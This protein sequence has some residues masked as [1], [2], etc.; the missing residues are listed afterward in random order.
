[1]SLSRRFI[2]V[3][4]AVTVVA[5]VV[6]SAVPAQAEVRVSRPGSTASINAAG[7]A[8]DPA[9]HV[10]DGQVALAHGAAAADVREF[11]AGYAASGGQIV[12][13]TPDAALSSMMNDIPMPRAC[14]GKNRQ[15]TTGLQSNVYI[16]SCVTQRVISL[17]GSGAGLAGI[18]AAV[19]AATGAG[20]IVAGV[21]AGLLGIGAGVLGSCSAKGRGVAIHQIVM[22]AITWCTSQ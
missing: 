1:M 10:F 5:S 16:D 22:S 8:V 21:I 9:T 19:T 12:R 4:L 2:H 7:G 6:A 18:V 20:P 14:A 17:M 11:A 3:A 13:A 15:D